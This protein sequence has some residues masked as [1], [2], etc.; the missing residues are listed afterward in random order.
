MRAFPNLSIVGVLFLAPAGVWA[1]PPV[2]PHDVQAG[3]QRYITICVSC[4]GADGDQV[5]GI[6]LGHGKFVHATTDQQLV[7]IIIHGIP[8]TGMPLNAMAES[9]ASAIVTYLHS[10][11]ESA[12]RN[13]GHGDA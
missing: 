4:H 7:D 10:M 2:D 6:D 3:E 1:Q 5:P 9:Q 11:A 8:G 13:T 12:S